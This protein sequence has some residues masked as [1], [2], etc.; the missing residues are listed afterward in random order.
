MLDHLDL[1]ENESIYILREAF[2][3]IDR[4]SMLWSVGKDSNVMV[5][6]A[7]KA[8]FG[9]VPFPVINLDT[10]KKM[11]EMYAFRDAIARLEPR[12]RDCRSARRS[13][14]IDPTLPPATR[15]A[16]RKT[17]GAEAGHRGA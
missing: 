4:L 12:S 14:Q 16:A 1:I 15:S 10:G 6:L 9:H 11:P 13:R 2:N 7:K 3:R 17:D 8:F 5:W